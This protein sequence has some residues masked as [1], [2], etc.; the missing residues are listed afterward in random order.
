MGNLMRIICL[1]NDIDDSIIYLT[2]EP[3]GE[4]THPTR[5]SIKLRIAVYFCQEQDGYFL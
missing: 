1:T 3:E 4:C 5:R 2:R